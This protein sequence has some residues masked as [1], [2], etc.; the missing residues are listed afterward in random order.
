[1]VADMYAALD[2]LSN[3]VLKKGQLFALLDEVLAKDLQEES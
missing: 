3:S 1:M 2:Q